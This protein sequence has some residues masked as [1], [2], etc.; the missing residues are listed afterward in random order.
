MKSM[1]GTNSNRLPNAC[2]RD[3]RQRSVA[4]QL[5]SAEIKTSVAQPTCPPLRCNGKNAKQMFCY[6]GRAPPVAGAD[7]RMLRA[8]CQTRMTYVRWLCVCMCSSGFNASAVKSIREKVV[9][10]N[11]HTNSSEENETRIKFRENVLFIA[12]R[13]IIH[14]TD[15]LFICR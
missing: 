5:I 11:N 4:N 9:A 7:T 6:C 15:L 13:P 1:R 12:L 2:E 14:T 10:A 3:H 8:I